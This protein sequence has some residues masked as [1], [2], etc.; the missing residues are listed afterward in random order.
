M[1]VSYDAYLQR[2]DRMSKSSTV[3][4]REVPVLEITSGSASG[5]TIHSEIL[6][7]PTDQRIEVVDLTDR[8]MVFVR[9]LRITEGIISLWSLRTTCTVFINEF[10]SALTSDIKRFFEQMVTRDDDWL[11]K[12]PEHSDCDRMNADSHI[13]TLLLGH[14]LTLQ[15]SG[16]EIVLGQWQRVLMAELDGP[17]TR[18]LRVQGWGVA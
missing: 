7:I 1:L 5:V 4:V 12:N 3:T 8:I 15:V 11:H 2:K 14:S 6:V 16:G 17:R 13:R 18:T 10:Q 9:N